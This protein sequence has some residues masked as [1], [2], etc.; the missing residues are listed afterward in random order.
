MKHIKLYEADDLQSQLEVL[1]ELHSSGLIGTAE[2]TQMKF[3]MAPETFEHYEISL[4]ID[5]ELSQDLNPDE[6]LADFEDSLI[7]DP[8][9]TGSFV[10]PSNIDIDDL[11]PGESRHLFEYTLQ[12]ILTT[13]LKQINLTQINDWV[14]KCTS[15]LFNY[16]NI[17]KITLRS[18]R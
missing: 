18:R 13:D 7:D 12:F 17:Q 6:I 5:W 4:T 10:R 1:D 11:D 14:S 16:A 15:Y 9:P 8:P 3:E 2:Y